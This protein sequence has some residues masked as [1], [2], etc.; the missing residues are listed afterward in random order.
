MPLRAGRAR[1][2]SRRR[3]RASA[4]QKKFQQSLR[5][6]RLAPHLQPQRLQGP[7]VGSRHT[8]LRVNRRRLKVWA[9]VKCHPNRVHSHRR[10]VSRRKAAL[11]GPRGERKQQKAVKKREA[12]RNVQRRLSTA[13]TR[14]SPRSPL[15]APHRLRR[16]KPPPTATPLRNLWPTLRTAVRSWLCGCVHLR[17]CCSRPPLPV[18]LGKW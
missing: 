12:V 5:L 8:A 1:E 10:E 15:P 4:A 9:P 18:L 11:A 6:S 14:Q 2:R 17:C 16:M 13:A 3:R 7:S